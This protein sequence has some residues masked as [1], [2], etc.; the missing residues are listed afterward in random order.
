M[1]EFTSS[2][3]T[4]AALDLDVLITLLIVGTAMAATTAIT[5]IVTRSSIRVSPLSPLL[6]RDL[7]VF[8]NIAYVSLY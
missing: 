2:C 8:F 3:I 5:A 6:P 1:K 7:V 4:S